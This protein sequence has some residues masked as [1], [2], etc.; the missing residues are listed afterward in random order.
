M[1]RCVVDAARAVHDHSV[2]KTRRAGGIVGSLSDTIAIPIELDAPSCPVGDVATANASEKAITA[3]RDPE[4]AQ[5][6]VVRDWR[7]GSRNPDRHRSV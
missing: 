6:L 2:A 5:P 7:V 4:S 3:T 1:E